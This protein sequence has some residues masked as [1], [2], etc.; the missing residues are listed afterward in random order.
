MKKLFAV[1]LTMCL[2]SCSVFKSDGELKP[3]ILY[4]VDLTNSTDDIFHVTVDVENFSNEN[5]I[6]NFAATAPGTYEI[7][8]FGRFVKSFKAFNNE[9]EELKV[10]K[11]STNRW[12]IKNCENLD[13]IVYHIEDTFDSEVKHN[14]A[15]M[16]GTSI[17]DDHIILNTFGVLGYFEGLQSNQL[18][19]SV[20]YRS[21]WTAGTSLE[22]GKDNFYISQTYDELTDCPILIGDLSVAEL[23]V[24]EI[25]VN[26]YTTKNKQELT[27]DKILKKAQYVF[28]CA[29]EFIGYNPV[30]EYNYLMCLLD[31]DYIRSE[32]IRNFGALEHNT[33]SLYVQPADSR[34]ERTISSTMAHEFMHILTPLNLHSELIHNFNFVNPTP[35]EHVWLYEGVTEWA[36]DIMELRSGKL[37]LK[38]YFNRISRHMS[39]CDR[40]DNSYSLSK[41]SLESYTDKGQEV[42]GNFYEKGALTAMLLDIRLL[43]LSNGKKGLREVFLGLLK[44]YGKD[45]PFSEKE[46]FNEFVEATYPEIQVFINDFIRGNKKLPIPEYIGK[47]G[48]QYLPEGPSDETG[49]DIGVQVDANKEGEFF[50]IQ[51]SKKASDYGIKNGDI[52]VKID[53]Q[54]VNMKTVRTIGGKLRAMKPG[55]KYKMLV[56]RGDKEI[57]LDAEI[58]VKMKK[59]IFND[60]GNISEQQKVLRESWIKNLM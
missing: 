11:I 40:Y 34:T 18:K 47:L 2:I 29:K 7:L 14:I 26:I 27:A 23:M 24:N 44:K 39:L 55:E 48:Y 6:Y 31:I 8:D 33:S 60:A 57:K 53:G 19:L 52:F 56:R 37:P 42:W 16:S 30:K 49:G 12:Q 25:K 15:P 28:E 1:I 17:E 41:M 3:T 32:G 36:A 21:D 58:F 20:D 22:K 13:K 5:N 50:A 46:F 10:E 51:V 45:K 4:N 59:H 35:S 43:E 54:E 9:G 38:Y